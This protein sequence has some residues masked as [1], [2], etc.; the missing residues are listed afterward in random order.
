MGVPY[1]NGNNNPS[2]WK[3]T[4]VNSVT[5]YEPTT[6]GADINTQGNITAS[7]DITS[8]NIP[9]WAVTATHNFLSQ[10]ITENT[11]LITAGLATPGVENYIKNYLDFDYHILL[12]KAGSTS[13]FVSPN[14][15][16]FTFT[17]PT[18]VVMI[19]PIQ[20]QF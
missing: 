1:G 15:P 10:S 4:I 5:V 13:H 6:D 11:P 17:K 16:I 19:I 3:S 12:P 18:R 7:G 8:A 20:Q 9:A 14:Q 2:E